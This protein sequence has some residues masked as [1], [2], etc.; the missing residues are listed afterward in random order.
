MLT[1]KVLFLKT[2]IGKQLSEHFHNEAQPIDQFVFKD[3]DETYYLI[4]GGWRHGN[5]A[6]LNEDFTGF[7]PWEDQELFK[8]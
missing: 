8:R 5:M 7:I 1:L 3:V 2:N 4:Y 6:I